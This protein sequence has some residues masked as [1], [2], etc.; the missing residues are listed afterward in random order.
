MAEPGILSPPSDHIEDGA[1]QLVSEFFSVYSNP[2][3]ISIFCALRDGR[4][5]VSELADLSGVSLQNASQH[6]RIMRDKGAVTAEREGQRVYYAISDPRFVA[7]VRLIYEALTDQLRRRA[8]QGGNGLFSQA[9]A[10]SD[11]QPSPSR[12][13]HA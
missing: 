11:E 2:T 8:G 9:R 4:K 6:L 1:C 7:G 13:G 10:I 5:T 12:V 3:R